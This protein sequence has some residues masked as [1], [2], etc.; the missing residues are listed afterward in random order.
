MLFDVIAIMINNFNLS[1]ILI[2]RNNVLVRKIYTTSYLKCFI[3]KIIA[4]EKY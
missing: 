1:S 4:R 3:S 2:Q